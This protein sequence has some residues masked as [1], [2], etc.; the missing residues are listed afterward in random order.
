[1][2]CKIKYNK[3]TPV[4]V[5]KANGAESQLFKDTF[6]HPIIE[7]FEDALDFYKNIYSDKLYQK[8]ENYTIANR[9]NGEIMTS[10][11]DALAT[12]A[13]E[14]EVGYLDN[15]GEFYSLRKIKPSFDTSTQKG[16][17]NTYIKQGFL[18]DIKNV[19]SGKSYF[20]SAGQTQI[21]SSIK[22]DI[23]RQDALVNLGWKKF[24]YSGNGFT[25]E[26]IKDPDSYNKTQSIVE[27]EIHDLLFRTKKERESSTGPK[28]TEDELKL[29]LLDLLDRMGVSVIS[30]SNYIE[31]YS[32]QSGVDPEARALADIANQI[33]AFADGNIET[34]D[35][36]EET[37][38]FIVESWDQDEISNLLKSINK[39]PQWAEHAQ[40]YTEIYSKDY[41]GAELDNIVRREIL[42]K[43]LADNLVSNFSTE[44]ATSTY[45]F[46]INK[47]KEFFNNFMDFMRGNYTQTQKEQLADFTEQVN[48]LLYEK[49]ISSLLDTE[50]FKTNSN[51]MYSVGRE[52]SEI[53]GMRAEVIEGLKFLQQT[54]RS[55][56]K[57]A[58]GVVDNQTLQQNIKK[59][60]QIGDQEDI[61]LQKQA[62]I[63]LVAVAD[64]QTNFLLSKIADKED[65]TFGAEENAAYQTL[66]RNINPLLKSMES[67]IREN[68][69]EYPRKDWEKVE[70]AISDVRKK[71][72]TLSSDSTKVYK[73]VINTIADRIIAKHNLN[74]GYKK[75]LE[76]WLE[77]A[78]QDTSIF[79]RYFGQIV[80]S[81]DPLLGMS[82]EV[83]E[84]ILNGANREYVN[85][86]KAFQTTIKELGLDEK[87]LKGFFNDGFL[88]D[89]FDHS[90][91]EDFMNTV[92][93]E[94][95]KIATGEKTSI[96]DIKKQ[97]LDNK[98]E[99]MSP[100]EEAAYQKEFEKRRSEFQ[101]RY[102]TDEYYKE[103]QDRF[104]KLGISRQT[105]NVIG[106]YSAARSELIGKAKDGSIIDYSKLSKTDKEVLQYLKRKRASD[107]SFFNSD[108]T[109]K[110]G[111][112]YTIE[113]P[114][115]GRFIEERGLFYSVDQTKDTTE[116]AIIAMDLHILDKDYADR[117]KVK[118]AEE[119][120]E[121]PEVPAIFRD[122][123]KEIEQSQGRE[124]ATNFI[125][126]NASIFFN[127]DFWERMSSGESYTDR[128]ANTVGELEESE[129]KTLL[130]KTI[131]ELRNSNNLRSSLLKQ[132]NDTNKPFEID[133][134][135]MDSAIKE[136]IKELDAEIQLAYQFLSKNVTMPEI[137][138]GEDV[139]IEN[140]IFKNDVNAAYLA[141]VEDR[142]YTL[143]EEIDFIK[144]NANKDAEEKI[145]TFKYAIKRYF[146]GDPSALSGVARS[147]IDSYEGVAI[148][149][150]DVDTLTRDFARTQVASYYKRLI[151]NEYSDI[152]DKKS[153]QSAQEYLKA[154]EGASY[155]EIAPNYSFLEQ[156][157]NKFINPNFLTEYEGAI[158]VKKGDVSYNSPVFREDGSFKEYV[159]KKQSFE[160]NKFKETFGSIK[161]ENSSKNQALYKGLQVVKD[162]Q[163]ESLK[164]MNIKGR[165]SL[166]KLPQQSKKG[167]D[168]IVDVVKRANK[169]GIGQGLEELFTFRVDDLEYGESIKGANISV[170]PTYYVRDLE[171]KAELS[172]ELFYTF[173]TMRQQA[174]LHKHRKKNIGEVL[175]IK[176]AL[177]KR[178]SKGNRKV[179]AKNTIEMFNNQMD[180][181]IFGKNET[182]EFKVN[183][184]GTTI[185]ITKTARMLLD[186][187]KFRNLGFSA[188]VG[189]TSYFSSEVNFQIEK[190]VGEITNT[191]SERLGRAA[192]GRAAFAAMSEVGKLK[193][194]S[195]LNTFGEFFGLFD[196]NARYENVNYGYFGRNLKNLGWAVHQMGNFPITP[197]VMY[198][199]L[200][201][202]RVVKG[203]I[204]TEYQFKI[205]RKIEDA[206]VTNS[207]L[208]TEWAEYESEVI[209]NY[210]D[211]KDGVKIKPE[212][213]SK[214]DPEFANDEYLEIKMQ[215]ITD[216]VKRAASQLD[217]QITQ[218]Q[219]TAA[220]RHFAMNYLMTHKGWLSV[221]IS[222][223]TKNAHYNTAT[224]IYE[225][226]SYKSF[227][228]WFEASVTD[229][230]SKKNIRAFNDGWNGKDL[231]RDGNVPFEELLAT[232]RRN[233][234]R[235][236]IESLFFTG[237][238]GIAYALLNYAD[239][240][241]DNYALQLTSYLSLRVLNE[242]ASGQVG[243]GYQ[244][245]ETLDS[246]F[247]GLATVADILA[248]PL[249]MLDSE[250]VKSGR[251]KGETVRMRSLKK[252]IPGL[253][254]FDDMQ[255]LKDTRDTYY[256]YNKN[257]I[258]F[259]NPIGAALVS[260]LE[261]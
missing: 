190:M 40:K 173:A 86:I 249:N 11:K 210:L 121:T 222:D 134:T 170:I 231:E 99:K 136:K 172:D 138:G 194:D 131:G 92:R 26:E 94:S 179:D 253:K 215:A 74:E 161:D 155:V 223:R 56:G 259:F 123:V 76:A 122:K 202:F 214:L 189:A 204:T 212:L 196:L 47:V 175:A 93:A 226:G 250:V 164:D 91:I 73:G 33:I 114:S 188:I 100:E 166:Y 120:N 105:I 50:N 104:D 18:S 103:K 97:A 247:V 261:D 228:K 168:R 113:E 82:S 129:N 58:R 216:K 229:M 227:Y 70:K 206:D 119:G 151:P 233:L 242:Q 2:S 211:K 234:R 150:A 64:S 205:D 43:V 246:P 116:E 88:L 111:I 67:N 230:V 169:G 148:E 90:K 78:K 232:R 4:A 240:D 69:K 51:V 218:S 95:R 65:Y 248:M 238:S 59:L 125:E 177:E 15:S 256:F 193:S 239:D 187:I 243:L 66:V 132:Y 71:I 55:Y 135:K 209:Y 35:L 251:Y 154:L 21:G 127:Q 174:I 79:H 22:E 157:D 37:A 89:E 60:Q 62:A 117:T 6:S 7:D 178:E 39:T 185:D 252:V 142:G 45:S 32:S 107:K 48:D 217:T 156:D 41:S 207:Q 27:K 72:D 46:I 147:F 152:F 235:V 34:K 167:V 126:S 198:A 30:M 213:K 244:M 75:D 260:G 176:D 57:S 118:N 36:A 80:N 192:F 171:N 141:E 146:N 61:L 181:A 133:A 153:Y 20:Q 106:N 31:K 109:F 81:N 128:L 108:G 53:K 144:K 115:T 83:I 5:E 237:L 101:Q 182:K 28:L 23:V 224:G 63:E 208:K 236:A 44:D 54:I 225:E 130:V 221:K 160:S 98:L 8:E 200:H 24:Q 1:M 29:R 245:Y 165:H 203:R 159:P 96:E 16:F 197:R 84:K 102:F 17:I 199:T 124:A 52:K 12:E 220:Q 85:E 140:P 201:D 195:E 137:E 68:P 19:V 219:R 162:L 110:M 10:Y 158:Q 49:Q 13:S 3:D 257:N 38:H 25:F 77:A 254:T 191:S 145:G 163:R 180:Y 9:V 183:F 149:E 14:I 42:G 139:E 241:E 186:F 258:K 143:K 87:D 184:F 112:S 255:K